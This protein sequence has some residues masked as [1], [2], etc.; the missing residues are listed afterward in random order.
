MKKGLILSLASAALMFS[1]VAYAAP[2]VPARAKTH[3]GGLTMSAAPLTQAAQSRTLSDVNA[4]P[5]R[6]T[7]ENSGIIS[8]APEG[9]TILYSCSGYGYTFTFMGINF[10]YMAGAAKEIVKTDDA[11]Y[12]RNPFLGLLSNSY[13]KAERNG[14]KYTAKLPVI[15]H[16]EE[17]YGTKYSYTGAI[18]R[19]K[20]TPEGYVIYEATDDT[21]VNFVEKDG[22]IILDLGYD[23]QPDDQGYIDAPDVIFGLI[24]SEGNWSGV[25]DGSQVYTPFT[26]TALTPPTDLKT[27]KWAMTLGDA[28]RFINVGIDGNDVWI[29]GLFSMLPEAWIKGEVKGNTVVVSSLQYLG[30]STGYFVYLINCNL[31]E[32]GFVTLLPECTFNYDAAG[33]YMTPVDAN[34]VMVFNAGNETLA[35]LEFIQAP[36]LHFQ[37][38]DFDK[39]VRNPNGLEFNDYFDGSGMAFFDFVLPIVS[40]DGDLLDTSTMYYNVLFDGEVE[41]FYND[42]YP[43]DVEDEI[44]DIPFS[45]GVQNIWYDRS[46][47]TG[48]HEIVIFTHGLK[49]IGVQLFN[50]DGATVYKSEIVTIPVGNNSIKETLPDA[51]AVSEEWYS[52]DGRRIEANSKGLTIRK[53]TYTDGTVRTF[54]QIVK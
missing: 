6:R 48:R 19:K 54:K 7:S 40:V 9:E 25:G 21:E 17:S 27:E 41:T 44:T 52:I 1:S 38:A 33:K 29:Q 28:G 35:Y 15:L 2:S 12:I 37:G 13:L 14:D 32:Q 8:T 34:D 45:F 50:K 49:T 31:N 39:K 53:V 23:P 51:E 22:N 4:A 5:A 42:E 11:I 3:N 26:E 30:M 10:T 43:Y 20:I 18:L 24:D 47:T 36:S 46:G 16:E